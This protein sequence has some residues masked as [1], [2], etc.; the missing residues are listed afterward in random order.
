MDSKEFIASIESMIISRTD[1]EP[2]EFIPTPAATAPETVPAI[3][4]NGAGNAMTENM[5]TAE[6][7]L[8]ET[9]PGAGHAGPD[10]VYGLHRR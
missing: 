2:A 5:A 1:I 7:P 10:N 6:T 8:P 9:Q 4:A 3:A